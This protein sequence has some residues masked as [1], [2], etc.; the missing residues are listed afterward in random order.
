MAAGCALTVVADAAGTRVLR[1]GAVVADRPGLLPPQVAVLETSATGASGLSVE[2]RT[3]ARY[4][5]TPTPLKTALLVVHALA[6]AALLV[7]AWRA[8]PGRGEGLRRPRASPAG[9]NI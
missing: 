9:A 6:L 4:Q 5:S 7:V 1:G 8:W 3:D 2:I